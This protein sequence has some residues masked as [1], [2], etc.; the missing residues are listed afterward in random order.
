MYN[1]V[2]RLSDECCYARRDLDKKHYGGKLMKKTVK[3]L[4]LGLCLAL[5]VCALAACDGDKNDGPA[6]GYARVSFMD[7]TTQLSYSD[8]EIGGKVTRPAE[9]PTKDGYDF[10]RWCATPNYSIAFDFDAEISKTT[11]VYAG[12]RSQAADDHTWYL[13]GSSLSDIFEESGDWADG[14]GTG[15]DKV[16]FTPETVPASVKLNK[17]ATKGNEFSI[18]HDFYKGDQFQILNTDQGWDGQLGYGYINADQYST[19]TTA[20]MYGVANPYDGSMTKSNITIGVSGNYTITLMVDADGKLTEFEYVR[21]GDAEE[22]PV[23]FNYFIKGETVTAWQNMLVDYTQFETE[24]NVVYTREMGMYANDSFMFLAT[25]IG[26][27]TNAVTDC[28][29]TAFTLSDD[30]D[31]A[32]AI[33]IANGNFKIKAG[34]GTYLFTITEATDGS[35]TLAAEKTAETFPEYDFYVK[36]S[37]GGDTAWE[38]RTPMISENGKYVLKDVTINENEAFQITVTNPGEEPATGVE[39]DAYS[40]TNQYAKVAEMSNQIDFRSATNNFVALASDTFTISIDPVTMLVTVEG[41]HDTIT[42]V[43]SI[44]GSFGGSS[45][46][47]DGAT[48]NILSDGTLT[49]SVTKELAVGDTFGFRTQKN[50]SQIGWFNASNNGWTGCEGLEGTGDI[51]VTAAGTYKFDFVITAD[52]AITS[53]TASVVTE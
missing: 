22:L 17:S 51:S 14:V 53:V 26:D 38:E 39:K 34:N 21:N 24:D 52:G 5:G 36:G 46:W 16:L 18:T 19:A 11:S 49:G 29:V 23:E 15:A 13:A 2:K 32:A 30:A 27:T 44:Y 40:I 42:W 33:E 28:G 47:A 3:A 31:T 37:I 41:E 8:V 50:G 1:V 20:N 45:G 12:F 7:G 4:T 6:D 9:D 43:T 35:R 10:V 48:V 25:Q